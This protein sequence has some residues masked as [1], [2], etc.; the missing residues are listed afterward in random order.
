MPGPDDDVMAIR[1]VAAAPYTMWMAPISLSACITV[2][3][4]EVQGLSAIRVSNISLWG[5][6]G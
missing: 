1:P 3:P 5:V 2:M 4:V 6:M